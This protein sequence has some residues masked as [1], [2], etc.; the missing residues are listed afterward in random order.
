[1]SAMSAS[2]KPEF[3]LPIRRGS[4]TF[5]VA[6]YDQS[7]TGALDDWTM[8]KREDRARDKMRT[9]LSWLRV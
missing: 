5:W 2:E 9:R 7:A 6:V 8:T 3:C 4:M 1:M